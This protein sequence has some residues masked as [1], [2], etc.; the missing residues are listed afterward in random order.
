VLAAIQ[1]Q[2][3]SPWSS[4]DIGD[5]FLDNNLSSYCTYSD[6]LTGN[7]PANTILFVDEIDSLFFSDAPIISH[8]RLL[9]AVLHLNKYKVIGMTA[10]FRGERG[11][12]MLKTFLEDSAIV[13]TGAVEAERLLELDIFGNLKATEID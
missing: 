10:T 12:N 11:L 1:Q 4:K 9:S 13:K 3:Y 5:L 8:N 2:K 6:L 7:I